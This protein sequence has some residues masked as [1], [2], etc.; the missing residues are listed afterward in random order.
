MPCKVHSGRNVQ[1]GME[2]GESSQKAINYGLEEEADVLDIKKLELQRLGGQKCH[3]DYLHVDQAGIQRGQ[4]WGRWG[5]A[6]LV[7]TII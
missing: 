2:W 1:T 4:G 7:V 3:C 5:D 6:Y